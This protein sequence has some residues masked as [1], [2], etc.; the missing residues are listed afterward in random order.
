MVIWHNPRCSK[1]RATLALLRDAG[2]EP[3]QRLYLDD[4]PAV[5]ELDRVLRALGVEPRAAAR[6]GEPI[7]G[8]MELADRE[9]SRSQWLETLSTH[10]ILIQRPIV[11]AD[12]GRAAIGRPPE[13]VLAL[14]KPLNG[15]HR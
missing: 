13:A 8:E 6:L 2:V 15:S 5:D 7:A 9:L 14:L 12:D 10:P 3:T 4:P 1:S 11:V